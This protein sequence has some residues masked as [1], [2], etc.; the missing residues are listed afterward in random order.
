MR[1]QV[2]Q[3]SVFQLEQSKC[4]AVDSCLMAQHPSRAPVLPIWKLVLILTVRQARL[5]A[6]RAY[7]CAV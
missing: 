1:L 6:Q 2:R 3:A 4:F 7:S 5:I